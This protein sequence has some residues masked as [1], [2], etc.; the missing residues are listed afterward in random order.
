VKNLTEEIDISSTGLGF[1]E[2]DLF[3]F[4]LA[5]A[6]CLG[7]TGIPKLSSFIEES[8]LKSVNG[9]DR[10]KRK[11]YLFESLSDIGQVLN[12]DMQFGESLGHRKHRSADTT[13]DI[14]DYSA[15]G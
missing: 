1:E 8:Q 13:A 2:V 15:L 14:D 5:I 10:K 4:D 6:Q 12:D 11:A 7:V 9:V 3:E